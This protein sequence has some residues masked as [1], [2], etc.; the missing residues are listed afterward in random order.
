VTVVG[1]QRV[2]L[3]DIYVSATSN[4]RNPARN[5]DGANTIFS[6]LITF[7]RWNIDNG[8]DSIAT[9]AN[10]TN[11]VIEDSIF[12]N[13]EGL[14]IGSVGQYSGQFER[15]ENITARNITMFGTRYTAR[16]KTWTGDQNGYPPNGGGG[17]LGCKAFQ[18][19][20]MT[21]GKTNCSPQMLGTS[22]FKTS[23]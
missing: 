16:V 21:L 5:T 22:P 10:S 8:D 1:S 12:H 2:L 20:D 13:G 23:L 7:R 17:G 3:E 6:D 4:S 18:S 19:Q 9:K 15:I 14:A 11:I